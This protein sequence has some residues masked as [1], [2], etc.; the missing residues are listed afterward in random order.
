MH[1]FLDAF[2][3]EPSATSLYTG[4]DGRM[5]RMPESDARALRAVYLGLAAEV[6][7]HIGR[8]TGYLKATGQ[9]E[10]TLIVVTSDHGEMLG[11]HFMWGKE[12]PF[13]PAIHVPL[14]I[15][16]PRRRKAAGRVVEAL[17]ES[18]DLAPTILEWLGREPPPAFD[19]YS[20]LPFLDDADP[21]G[22]RDHVFFEYDLGHPVTPTRYQRRLGLGLEQANFAL[23]RERRFKYVHFNGGLPPLL[24]DLEADPK[25]LRNLAGDPAHAP[26][27]LRLARRM[28]DHRMAKAS[29]SHSRMHLTAEGVKLAPRF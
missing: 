11:D 10:D 28:L 7:H 23:L 22:W 4:F 15:R 16:D 18:I 29:C 8:L 2:F 27:L 26:E 25:E 14:V 6:D 21:E 19:G 24:F 5:D 13:D 20:L 9:Y 1:P 12:S 17:T 3:A